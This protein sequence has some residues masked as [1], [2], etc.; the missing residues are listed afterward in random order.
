MDTLY[1]NKNVVTRFNKE[2]IEQCNFDSFREI[3]GDEFVN[4]TAP[5]T[6]NG[7]LTECGILSMMFCALR[8][9]TLQ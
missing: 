5:P 1:Q 9:Q 3:M 8:S 7:A 2:V 6:S 4:M